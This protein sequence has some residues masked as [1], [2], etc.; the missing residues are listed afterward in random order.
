[1][2]NLNT[3]CQTLV[4][5]LYKKGVRY[6]CISPGSRNTP[7]SLSFLE[8][9]NIKCYSILDER[10]S[11]FL[12]LGIAL[13]TQTP[14]TLICTSGTALANYLPSVI[15]S[16]LNRVPLIFLSADRPKRLIGTGENQ[17]INQR[18]IF[19]NFNRTYIDIGLPNENYNQLINDL[20]V[21]INASLGYNKKN[22]YLPGPIH[23]NCQFDEP[24]F[25]KYHKQ[26]LNIR[27][28]SINYKYPKIE[29]DLQSY[30]RPLII[31]GRNISN[32]M[33]LLI[34]L[35]NYLNA[36]I[37]ADA[38]SQI[39]YSKHKNII[40][41]YNHYL[42][43]I[44]FE[45]DV[46]F[47]FGL[48]PV[49]KLL[50]NKIKEWNTILFDSANGYNNYAKKIINADIPTACKYISDTMLESDP[51]MLKAFIKIDSKVNAI[52]K[53]NI[54]NEWSESS[55]TSI[56]FNF[57]SNKDNIFIGNSMPI[58]DVDNFI[59][60]SNANIN[61]FANRGASG[62]DGVV[63]SAIGVA[64]SNPKCKTLLLIGDLSFLHDNNA[65]LF[66]DRNLLNMTIVII[67]NNGGG[68]FSSLP[69]ADEENAYF[70]DFWTSP[71][72]IDIE[73]IATSYDI[74]YNTVKSNNE[75]SY[76]LQE[77]FSVAGLY[78]INALVDINSSL[79]SNKK[80]TK[81][82]NASLD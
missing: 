30:S 46:V 67:N 39:R 32:D 7:L 61:T 15:E 13:K 18:N 6:A 8:H 38:L 27:L 82:I 74:N 47:Y 66:K 69:V 48:P 65:L 24:L 31:C 34:K 28:Q 63:S 78:I 41:T 20:D 60:Y 58:R 51:S 49:S 81:K 64:E 21:G 5:V 70:P 16:D 3:W 14:V 59:G 73:K 36:P 76:S 68:I 54:Y 75:L 4:S 77:S 37:L 22:V 62:I 17:T 9:P 42:D 40:S 79:E 45:P 44:N 72:D 11:G 29:L 10:S 50:N 55:I 43:K 71:Q 56:C 53:N 26:N 57:L 33:S 12:A 25:Y 80:L 19:K 2:S 1:M 23:I 35:S 52:I